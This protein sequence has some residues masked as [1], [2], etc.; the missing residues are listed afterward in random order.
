MVLQHTTDPLHTLAQDQTGEGPCSVGRNEMRK[1]C[2]SAAQNFESLCRPPIR[3]QS[4]DPDR[5]IELPVGDNNLSSRQ[6][7]EDR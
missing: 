1:S 2:P 4:V 7:V 6:A 5:I 3:I